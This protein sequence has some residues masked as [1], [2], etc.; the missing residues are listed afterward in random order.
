MAKSLSFGSIS[1]SRGA[2]TVSPFDCSIGLAD[3][4]DVNDSGGHDC[5]ISIGVEGWPCDDY[6]VCG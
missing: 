6:D 3:N 2:G 5:A 1:V 4:N